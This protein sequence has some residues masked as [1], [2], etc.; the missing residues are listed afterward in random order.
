M[1]ECSALFL[2]HEKDI[3]CGRFD[4]A[5]CDECPS[6]DSLKQIIKI[7]IEKI[8]RARSVVEIEAAGH[9]VIPGLLDE[10]T[11]TGVHL[12]EQKISRKYGNLQKLLPP[13]IA[14]NA[15]S[16]PG[17]YYL[18]LRDIVDFISGMTDRHAI[19][20]YRKIKGMSL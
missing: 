12:M 8:Y 15:K 4:Q 6:G 11:Q 7:S 20:L 16:N 3:L 9:E 13:E 19:S 18:M 1:D 14:V 17:N 5:L 2:E 10:F